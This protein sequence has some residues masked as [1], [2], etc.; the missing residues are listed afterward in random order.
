MDVNI[1]DVTRNQSTAV[2]TEKKIC[3]FDNRYDKADITGAA[4][5]KAGNLVA[6]DSS[7]KVVLATAANLAKVIGV[8]IESFVV[9]ASTT[10]K[11]NYVVSGTINENALVLPATITL[12]SAVAEGGALLR[13]HLNGLGLHLEP[14]QE[15]MY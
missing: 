15:Q 10:R 14:C 5:I 2:Y 6:R 1:K 11:V 3:L 4:D 9:A 8:A 13:D 12:N 7:G